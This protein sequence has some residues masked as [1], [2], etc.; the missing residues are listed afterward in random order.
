MIPLSGETVKGI[1]LYIIV[2]KNDELNTK[3]N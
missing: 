3:H 1:L 2:N